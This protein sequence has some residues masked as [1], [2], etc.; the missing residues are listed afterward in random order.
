MFQRLRV[1][2]ISVGDAWRRSRQQAVV[3]ALGRNGPTDPAVRGHPRRIAGRR[4]G[5]FL[6]ESLL[7]DFPSGR[8]RRGSA[9]SAL[10][11]PP[12]EW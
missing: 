5:S 6:E 7:I 9:I 2:R 11:I 3:G 1:G 4:Y 12:Q 10:A 8:R